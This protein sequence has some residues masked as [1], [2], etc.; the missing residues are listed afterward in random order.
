CTRPEKLLLVQ[1]AQTGLVNPICK[2]TLHDLIRKKLVILKPYPRVM[3]ESFMRFLLSATSSEQIQAWE[4]E[5]GESH[6]LTVRNVLLIMVAFVFLIVGITQD[7]VLQ[8]ISGI[9]TAVVA[10]LGGVFKLTET[11]ASKWTGKQANAQI[12]S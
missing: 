8:S 7:R 9:L 3:N 6:W 1:L 11:I 12:K 4:K 10:G 5:A 2:D